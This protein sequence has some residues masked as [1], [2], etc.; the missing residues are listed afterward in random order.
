MHQEV[1]AVVG[2]L[3]VQSK[4]LDVRF[5]KI[6]ITIRTELLQKTELLGTQRI[7]RQLMES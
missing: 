1:V 7:L 3:G 4:R 2:A 6:K 5:E